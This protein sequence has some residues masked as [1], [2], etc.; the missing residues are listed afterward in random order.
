MSR[1]KR[2]QE[3]WFHRWKRPW[4]RPVEYRGASYLTS[5]GTYAPLPSWSP[6]GDV[7]LVGET[8]VARW[9]QT[10]LLAHRFATVGALVPAGFEAYVRIL[11]PAYRD[12]DGDRRDEPIP[13]S[14][15]ARMLGKSVH[16]LVQFTKLAGRTDD[17]RW[18]WGMAPAEGRLPDEVAQPLVR[19]LRGHTKTPS[20]CWYA[21]WYGYGDLYALDG[22]DPDTYPH[23]KSP[24]RE[25]LLFKG[26]LDDLPKL[27]SSGGDDPTMWWPDDRAWF[28]ATEIDLDSTYVGGSAECIAAIMGEQQLETFP[29][30]LD[31]RVD[32][33]SDTINV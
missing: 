3:H 7:E 22:Y 21:L 2:P 17:E 30:S 23:V 1:K 20:E 9:V 10:S 16:P 5:D 14:E 13:W 12:V 28:V 31:D 11:H 33:G 15:V 24:G 4:R 25:Y 18:Q 26:P 19:V 32:W 6:P 29:A 8:A 27:G